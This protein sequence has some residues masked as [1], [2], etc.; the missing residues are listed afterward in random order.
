MC[1]SQWVLNKP[2]GEKKDRPAEVGPF[3]IPVPRGRGAPET[4]AFPL[5]KWRSLAHTLGN[6]K[7]GN[8]ARTGEA[9]GNLVEVRRVLTANRS[10]IWV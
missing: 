5:W 9:R 4:P 3:G 1:A 10:Q 7:M 6:P 8:Y 2:G